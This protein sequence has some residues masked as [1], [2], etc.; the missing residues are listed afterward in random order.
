MSAVIS[1][2]FWELVRQAIALNSDAFQTVTTL[3]EANRIATNVLLLAGLSQ[4]IGQSIILF[5]NR[6]KPLRFLLSLIIAGIL[7]VF[8]Y[9]F[10]IGST[11]LVSRLVFRQTL[12]FWVFYHTIGLAAAPQILSFM[13]AM[14]YWG[15]PLQILFSLWTL[16]AFIKGFNAMT[17]F[18][19]WSIFTCSVLGWFVLQILQRT[20]GKP[21]SLLG[22]W[23]A[24]TVAGTQLVTDLKGVEDLLE[25]GLQSS[26]HRSNDRRP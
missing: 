16:L 2:D 23:L 14:P 11:W 3:P 18:G 5:I 26:P 15:V 20:I 10:W 6:V 9:G 13:V 19:V 17:G 21:F 7:F 24:N 8:S 22:G 12:D 4:A 25:T 1:A